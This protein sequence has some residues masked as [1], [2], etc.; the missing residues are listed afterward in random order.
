[1]PGRDR[2][3]PEGMGPLTGRQMGYCGDNPTPYYGRGRG[4][5]RLGMAFRHGWRRWGRPGMGVWGRPGMGDWVE[6]QYEPME[7]KARLE[8]EE[9]IL[10]Q[11]LSEV[12]ERIN[13]MQGK[14]E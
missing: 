12:Q 8:E 6:P 10:K 14:T 13:K 5:Y 9:R 7:E 2:S 1:M 11:Q 4:F 3:G